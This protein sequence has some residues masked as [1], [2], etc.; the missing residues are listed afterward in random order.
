MM[1]VMTGLYPW[2]H[3]VRDHNFTLSESVPMLA[4]RLRK[5]GYST[6]AIVPSA[7]L[8]E[9]FGFAR[10]FDF[11]HNGRYGHDVITSPALTGQ[12]LNWLERPREGP[13]FCWIHL[14]DPHYNYLPAAPFDTAFATPFRPAPGVRYDLTSLKNR[15]WAVRREE[16]AFLES[17]YC[18]EILYTDRYIGELIDFLDQKGLGRKTIV[19]LMGD[20]GEA[21]QEHGWLTHTMRVYEEMTRVP[22]LV[23]WPERQ[24]A[25]RRVEIPVSLVNVAPTILDMLGQPVPEG[26]MEGRSLLPLMRGEGAREIP[27]VTS[28]TI[29]QAALAS[30]REDDWKYILNLDTCEGEMYN[31]ASDPAEKRNLLQTEPARASR[32][33]KA[34][35]D[36]YAERPLARRFPV[37]RI[38]QEKPEDAELLRALGYVAT[39]RF[40]DV[41]T[42]QGK[43]DPAHCH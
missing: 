30:W 3:H 2:S 13:F 22:L 39:D 35:L 33:R 18:G 26:E 6:A 5:L 12:A 43:T 9:D 41:V 15:E 36:F 32:M 11:Y 27:P 17:Q 1:S 23:R 38:E 21:F 34:I 42:F 25:G 28:E 16:A 31:L 8:R 37:A 29:R 24:N 40:G 19:V 4:E 10:G 7:T 20:H 14:W